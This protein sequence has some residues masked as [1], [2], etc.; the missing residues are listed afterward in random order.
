MHSATPCP[1]SRSVRQGAAVFTVL[2][3]CIATLAWVAPSAFAAPPTWFVGTQSWHDPTEVDLNRLERARV[4]IFRMQLSWASVESTRGRYNWSR[5]D[6]LIR[7]AAERNVSIMPVLLGSPSWVKH[8][9]YGGRAKAQ[10]PPMTRSQRDAFY[11]F[12]RAAAQR[13]GRNGIFWKAHPEL[14]ESTQVRYW[15]VWNEPNLGNYWNGRPSARQYALMLVGASDAARRGDPNALVVATGLPWSGGSNVSPPDFL[16]TMF[17]YRPDLRNRI[18]SVAIHPYDASPDGVIEGVRLARRGL[19]GTEGRY[20]NLWLTE[21]GWATGTAS[22]IRA[23]RRGFTVSESTQG[24]NLEL[25]YNKLLSV[26]TRYRIKG[27]MWF[28]LWDMRNADWWAERTGLW[29]TNNSPK[30]SWYRLACV[31]RTPDIP[32]RR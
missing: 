22:Q 23:D 3:V 1:P 9:A 2:L 27:A 6:R 7:E 26:R 13:Y 31:T 25:T 30:R 18:N 14:P 28:N 11:R 10:Y 32:C 20:K 19:S 8:Q 24:R 29:R 16:R 12:A 4:G 17:T 5:Y 15:Q 21:F